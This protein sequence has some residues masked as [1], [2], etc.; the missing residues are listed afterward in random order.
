MAASINL[1]TAGTVSGNTHQGRAMPANDGTEDPPA[2]LADVHVNPEPDD[3]PT[4]PGIQS[5]VAQVANYV[6]RPVLSVGA[7]AKQLGISPATLR[8]W[9]R[10]YGIGPTDRA[11]GAHRRYSAGD[12]ERLAI[13]RRL[14]DEGVPTAAAARAAVAAD[15]AAV[16]MPT[17]ITAPL[18]FPAVTSSVHVV[19]EAVQAHDIVLL[20]SLLAAEATVENM[21]T[22][23][24]EPV[25][26]QLHKKTQISQVA[27]DTIETFRAAILADLVRRMQSQQ[28]NLQIAVLVVS[29]AN[30]QDPLVCHALGTALTGAGVGAG[31]V[32]GKL[33]PQTLGDLVAQVKPAVVAVV[34]DEHTTQ[35]DLLGNLDAQQVTVF[36]L[37]SPA[38]LLA[39][40]T[41]ERVRSF[42]G[43]V[44][45][46]RAQVAQTREDE[47]V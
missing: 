21:W 16:P 18:V 35:L 34:A 47:D 43:A 6:D 27:N 17:A 33:T 4:Q 32:R 29:A 41:V 10:R 22:E 28:E 14:T 45:E 5:R 25:F 9:G 19:V 15:L 42:T 11:S 39:P 44:H 24:V 20:S 46:I 3:D 38:E 13:M 30:G 2:D 36:L 12:M 8:T 26:K 1:E 37:S 7:V 31:V 40:I 23:L